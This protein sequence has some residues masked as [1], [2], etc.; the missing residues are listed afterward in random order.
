[1]MENYI[2]TA[3]KFGIN[4]I[5]TPIFTPP[6][7][8]RFGCERPTVQLIDVTREK[9]SYRFDFSKLDR[10]IEMCLAVGAEYF[11]M[12]HLFTQWGAAHAPKIMATENGEYK[13]IFGW[14]TDAAGETYQ[15][16]L[17]ALLPT[18]IA[19]L[20]ERGVDKRCYWHISDEPNGDQIADYK[21]AKAIVEPYLKD[22]VIMDAISEYS[23]YADGILETPIP[24]D[25]AIKPFLEHRV[26]DLWTYFCMRPGHAA[27]AG[28]TR[29]YGACFYRFNIVGFLNWGYNFYY[30]RGS[31]RPVD[32]YRDTTAEMF[33][34]A[35]DN[36]VVYPG[37]GGVP[38]AGTRLYT[39]LE[40]L[41]DMRALK[42][43]EERY[44]R[45]F[46]LKL[47]DDTL[48]APLAFCE[49]PEDNLFPLRLREKVNRLLAE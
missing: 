17:H 3:V 36:F 35:G 7:D 31:L 16:F 21:R 28:A 13:R 32:P 46:T 38:L 5:L 11:E 4:M 15:A 26:S 37:E 41:Q 45:D 20:K 39:F 10:F 6:L 18:L 47:I 42:L 40:A 2:G 22:Y 44:G 23:F 8:T 33:V 49:Y 27:R 19:H 9:G 24:R 29:I 48:G 30:S 1:M 14:E 43:C 34:P 25:L 12:A